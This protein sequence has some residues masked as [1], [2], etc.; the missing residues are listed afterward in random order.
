MAEESILEVA[1]VELGAK[2]AAGVEGTGALSGDG[3][4]KTFDEAYVKGLRSEAAGYRSKLRELEAAE[5]ERKAE[6]D[7]LKSTEESEVDRLTAQLAAS[8]ER[9]RVLEIERMRF[10]AASAHGVPEGLR[11][12]IT[13][14]DEAGALA[15]AKK[16]ATGLRTQPDLPPAGGRNPANGGEQAARLDEQQ[17]FDVL[18]Q[19]VPALNSRVLRQ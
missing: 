7:V 12:F 3:A 19:K 15:Q 1:A 9:A 10:S 8:E 14:D 2:S 17:R 18:R 11:E 16:L 5:A 4:P 6:E 13:A